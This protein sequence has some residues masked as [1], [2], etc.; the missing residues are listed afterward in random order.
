M[1]EFR[2][3]ETD[4]YTELREFFIENE[5]EFSE[6]DPLPQDLVKCF[7]L[8]D[9]GGESPKLIGGV[10]LAIR[11]GV[12]LIDGIAVDAGYRK[13]NFGKLLMDKAI[14]EVRN[15]SGDSLYLVARVPGFYKALGFESIPKEGAPIHFGCLSC[16]QFE[17]SCFPEVMKLRV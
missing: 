10:A 2:L 9:E 11:D 3:K 1:V 4:D 8:T 12:F 7:R 14:E 13:M 5:L 17:V 16:S 15:R 6:D